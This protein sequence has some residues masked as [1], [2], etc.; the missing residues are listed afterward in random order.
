MKTLDK[1]ISV[2]PLSSRADA[3]LCLASEWLFF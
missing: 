1:S 2:E 3:K